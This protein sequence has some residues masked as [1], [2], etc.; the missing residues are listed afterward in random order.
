MVCMCSDDEMEDKKALVVSGLKILLSETN[1]QV[2][3]VY[4]VCLFARALPLA[5]AG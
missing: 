3:Q 2:N 1:N 5:Y 4:V